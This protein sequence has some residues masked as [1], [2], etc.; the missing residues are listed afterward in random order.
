MIE[1]QNVW[2]EKG[3]SILLEDVTMAVRKGEFVYLI[4]PSGAGK[5]T[6]LRLIYFDERP[7]RGRV[8]VEG[9]NSDAI[10]D[11]D[12][13]FIRRKIGLIFQDFNLLRD[14]TVLDNVAFALEVTGASRSTLHRRALA[15]LAAVGMTQK[16]N[17]IPDHLS[18]GE[19]QRVVIARALVNEPVLLL[20][21]EPT[22]N[23]DARATENVTEILRNIHRQGTAV[24]VATHDATLTQRSPH[25]TVRL[26][27]GKIKGQ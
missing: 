13:P 18:G 15:A 5:S 11:R 26:E 24:I 25:R 2:V 21:D 8:A 17:E 7:T 14:R 27:S 12:I 1:L 4:G 9:R 23:L 16:R 20:A 19:R 6:L 22:G 10:R 3:D